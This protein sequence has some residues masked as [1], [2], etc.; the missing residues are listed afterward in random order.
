MGDFGFPT[1]VLASR[2]GS[3]L[4]YTSPA[5]AVVA[6][7]QVEP[8]T[9]ASLYRFRGIGPSTAVYGVIGN[10]VMHSRSPRIHNRG[11]R[12]LGLDAVYLPFVVDDIDAFWE[13][14][15]A[16]GIRGFS[17]TAP[18]KQAVLGR[19]SEADPV[20]RATGACNTVFRDGVG[21]PWKGTNTDVAGFL[22]TA[23]G[24]LRRRHSRGPRRNGDRRRA[25]RRAR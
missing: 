3:F 4:C 15:D 6:P 12:S 21:K 20:V 18:H 7:G 10:P 5:G 11:F 23:A 14:A 25:G 24:A 13:V 1:R 19:L 9:L 22:G 8:D 17:V 2:L 16:L